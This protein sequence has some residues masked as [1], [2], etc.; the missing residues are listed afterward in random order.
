MRR[1]SIRA[2]LGVGALLAGI[3]EFVNPFGPVYL[4]RMPALLILIGL[5]MLAREAIWRQSRTREEILKEVPR[6]PLGLSD[7]S[8]EGAAHRE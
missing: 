5:V 4:R 8:S 2:V 7:D 6:K 1:V 3:A